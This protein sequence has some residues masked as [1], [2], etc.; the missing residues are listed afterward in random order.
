[1]P[2]TETLHPDD[3]GQVYVSSPE[4]I[5]AVVTDRDICAQYDVF[6]DAPTVDG[7][8]ANSVQIDRAGQLTW[9]IGDLGRLPVIELDSAYDYAALGWT[10]AARDGSLHFTSDATGTTGAITTFGV[11]PIT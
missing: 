4:G 10:L 8:Q 6:R 7:G 9:K 1:M 11:I 3:Y 5:R 2:T